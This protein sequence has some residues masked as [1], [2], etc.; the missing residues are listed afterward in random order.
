LGIFLITAMAFGLTTGQFKD[1]FRDRAFWNIGYVI[2]AVAV[3]LTFNRIHWIA[4][5]LFVFATGMTMNRRLLLYAT[6]VCILAFL[7]VPNVRTR[8][9]DVSSTTTLTG[10]EVIWRAAIEKSGNHPVFGYG[11]RTFPTVFTYFSLLE[12]KKVGS[13]HNDALEIYMESG[14]VGL[15]AYLWLVVMAVFI[16]G[17]ALLNKRLEPFYRYLAGGLFLAISGHLM[18][19]LTGVFIADPLASLLFK[20]C[21]ALTGLVGFMSTRIKNDAKV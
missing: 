4:L 11:P 2:C 8:I 15:L 16:L 21:L 7:L 6:T 12:D 13:W 9:E 3:I 10:R 20:E 5:I 14:A 1:V 18:S 17:K 19:G